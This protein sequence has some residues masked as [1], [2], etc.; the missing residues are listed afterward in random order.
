LRFSTACAAVAVSR[1][2]F[3]DDTF[4]ESHEPMLVDMSDSGT[5]AEAWIEAA[6]DGLVHHFNAKHISPRGVGD[7]L[8]RTEPLTN[9][10]SVV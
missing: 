5:L 1:I 7:I 3:K 8:G 6:A 10:A 9:I 4:L 2:N